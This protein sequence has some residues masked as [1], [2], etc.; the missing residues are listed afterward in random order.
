MSIKEAISALELVA[1]KNSEE[2]NY[3]LTVEPMH[4]GL[5]YIFECTERADGHT[6]IDGRGRSIEEAID[7]AMSDLD[8]VSK[9][10]GYA[11]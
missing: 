7:R 1:E 8:E 3:R 9:S 2:F 11:L 4:N 5:L 10:W 6:F